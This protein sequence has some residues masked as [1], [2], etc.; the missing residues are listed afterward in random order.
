MRP[1][2]AKNVKRSDAFTARG[3]MD[4]LQRVKAGVVLKL[5]ALFKWG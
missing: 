3:I 4:H 2:M 1:T 5:V